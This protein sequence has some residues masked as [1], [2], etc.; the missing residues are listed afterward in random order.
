MI[1]NKFNILDYVVFNK[2]EEGVIIGIERLNED[3]IYYCILSKTKE[4]NYASIVKIKEGSINNIINTIF[5]NKLIKLPDIEYICDY[6]ENN[7]NK[8]CGKCDLGNYRSLKNNPIILHIGD[9]VKDLKFI[10]YSKYSKRKSLHV[11]GIYIY[12]FLTYLNEIPIKDKDVVKTFEIGYDRNKIREICLREKFKSIGLYI[13]TISRL[14]KDFELF[15][16]IKEYK[17]LE[18]FKS[19]LFYLLRNN[20]DKLFLNKIMSYKMRSILEIEILN[21][22]NKLDILET[23]KTKLCSYCIFTDNCSVC[24]FNK[25]Y[26]ELK[27][28]YLC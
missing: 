2:D 19:S 20:K 13:L 9:E 8:A 6:C 12:D 23:I 16:N 15:N 24:R 18:K 4:E 22:N 7:K 27:K 25:K 10:E 17:F 26:N 3:E 21:L 14:Y 28:N 5:K 11:R 1:S